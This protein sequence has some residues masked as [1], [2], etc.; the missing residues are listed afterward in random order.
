MD[1]N[2]LLKDLVDASG[3]PEEFILKTLTRILRHGGVDPANAGIEDVRKV[4]ADYLLDVFSE[5]LDE[6]LRSDSA[7]A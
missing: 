1:D 6:G 5:I 3:L 7:T 2:N 4:T